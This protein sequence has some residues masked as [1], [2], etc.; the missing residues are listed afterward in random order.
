MEKE[1][2]NK[3]SNLEDIMIDNGDS[4]KQLK[5]ILMIVALVIVILI[6]AIAATKIIIGDSEQETKNNPPVNAPSPA[7]N[8]DKE[9]L[10]EEV[11]MQTD[12]NAD[13]ELEKMITQ[14]RDSETRQQEKEKIEQANAQTSSVAPEKD[15]ADVTNPKEK[16]PTP[17]ENKKE[18]TVKEKEIV[19]K[20]PVTQEYDP[21]KVSNG[22]YVQVGSFSKFAPNQGFLNSIKENGYKYYFYRTQVNDIQVTKVIIG[23]YSTKAQVD[24]EK[25]VI[26]KAINDKAFSFRV[27]DGN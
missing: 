4:Q 9:P 16:T 1:S 11:P 24:K 17:V 19:K 15:K 21:Y 18:D 26:R 23:P 20:A 27:D 2:E 13:A 7:V 5:K 22:W 8:D 10:F 12:E 3:K 25:V 14:L 6:V